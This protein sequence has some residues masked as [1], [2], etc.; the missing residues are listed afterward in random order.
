M[1]LGY[2]VQTWESLIF[3]TVLVW[4]GKTG[5][6]GLFSCALLGHG[7]RLVNGEAVPMPK[8]NTF[9]PLKAILRSLKQAQKSQS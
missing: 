4:W 6:D 5:L 2:C 1:V 8:N 9:F 3:N 7:H